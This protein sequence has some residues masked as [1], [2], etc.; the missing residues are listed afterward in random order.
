MSDRDPDL[1]PTECMSG[2]ILSQ[3][4]RVIV[5]RDG[6]TATT[7][8]IPEGHCFTVRLRRGKDCTSVELGNTSHGW[9]VKISGYGALFAHVEAHERLQVDYHAL[10]CAMCLDVQ[11]LE[12][13]LVTKTG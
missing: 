5:K 4:D 11:A 2:R 10:N 12:P 9:T 1:K 6:A 7:V 8:E 3:G 13:W